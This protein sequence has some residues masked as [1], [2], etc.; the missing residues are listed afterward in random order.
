MGILLGWFKKLLGG[1]NFASGAV[2]G[3]WIFYLCVFCVFMFAWTAISGKKTA[4]TTT[5]K[6]E[7]IVSPTY[8]PRQS[9]GC[10][11]ID[12]KGER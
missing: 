2:I 12:I 5:Q 3:K 7:K 4:S 10:M 1:F 8:S 9:F 6:A 11:R